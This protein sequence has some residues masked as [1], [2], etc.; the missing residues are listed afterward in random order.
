MA[1][2]LDLQEQ[3]QIDALKAFWK[4]YG[5]L[6]TWTLTLAL[7]VFAAWNGWNWYQRDQALK[8][9]VMYDEVDKS[10]QQGD[11]DKA[12]R[13]FGELRERYPRTLF[14]SQAALSLARLQIDKGKADDARATL[15]WVSENA[16]EDDYRAVAQLRLAGLHL[17]AQRY[18]EA[19][20][21]LDAATVA[22]FEPLVAD[23]R[24]DVLLAEGKRAEAIAAY[25]AAWK[26][27]PESVE[28]RRLVEAKLT[29]LAAAP[30]KAA[31]GAAP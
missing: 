1:T 25:Q 16:R 19:L 5:N 27:L 12:G 6:L 30:D 7:A 15:G 22:S 3:E 26:G 10:I 21:A 14:V 13:L 28:Y 29:S 20:R 8:A 9:S 11:V 17:D 31:S 23:R 4:Q 18:D 24:G 2:Q